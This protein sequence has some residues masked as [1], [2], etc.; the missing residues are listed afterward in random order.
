MG[1]WSDEGMR[2]VNGEMGNGEMECWGEREMAWRNGEGRG[3]WLR[4]WIQSEFLY[5][6]SQFVRVG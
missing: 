3:S 2:K 6:I 1:K 4:L 5:S